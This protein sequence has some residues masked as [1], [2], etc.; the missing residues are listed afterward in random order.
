M[1]DIREVTGKKREKGTYILLA[2]LD[3]TQKIKPGKLPKADYE[4]GIY[5]YV[6]RAKTGLKARIERHLRDDKKLFWHI[7]YLL[8]RAKIEA[9]WIRRDYF[10]ECATADNIQDLSPPAPKTIHGFGSSDCR[11]TGHLFYFSP[12]TNGLNSLR[13]KLGFMKAGI[14]GNNI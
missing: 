10:A 4:K 13:K 2:S 14:D 1:A 11:C 12:E 7:D 6:G 5:L 8:Q 3:K 9:V